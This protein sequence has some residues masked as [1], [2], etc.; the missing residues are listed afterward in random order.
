[1]MVKCIWCILSIS[2]PENSRNVFCAISGTSFV[3][4]EKSGVSRKP[5]YDGLFAELRV[6]GLILKP[7]F[8]AHFRR[9]K[10][11]LSRYDPFLRGEPAL[12]IPRKSSLAAFNS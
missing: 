10:V 9:H 11:S 6:L 2:T 1:M 7:Q 12:I 8:H 5:F 4:G 3:G